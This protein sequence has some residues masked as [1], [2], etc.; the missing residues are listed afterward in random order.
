VYDTWNVKYGMMK[1]NENMI[2]DIFSLFLKAQ[3]FY[4][5]QNVCLEIPPIPAL[6]SLTAEYRITPCYLLQ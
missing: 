6:S 4:M 5:Q 1:Y 3:I 2:S